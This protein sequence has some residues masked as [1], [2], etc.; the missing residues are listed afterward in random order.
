MGPGEVESRINEP[1]VSFYGEEESIFSNVPLELLSRIFSHLPKDHEGCP[2]VCRRWYNIF[3]YL[4]DKEIQE[5]YPERL[6]RVLGGV[7]QVRKL[8]FL[9]KGNFKAREFEWFC[10]VGRMEGNGKVVGVRET[11]SERKTCEGMYL[12]SSVL[13]RIDIESMSA[14]ILRGKTR[15]ATDTLVHFIAIRYPEKWKRIIHRSENSPYLPYRP[16]S[17]ELL[18]QPEPGNKEWKAIQIYQYCEFSNITPDIVN[19]ERYD[20]L[21]KFLTAG[22]STRRKIFH[23][24][25]TAQDRCVRCVII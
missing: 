5:N 3:K 22:E 17:V 16:W 12:D 23:E 6:V 21:T 20:T 4:Q 10:A 25:P 13:T 24:P 15:I 2:L 11:F 8:P 18:F 1:S 9:D 19:E 14:P 7:D